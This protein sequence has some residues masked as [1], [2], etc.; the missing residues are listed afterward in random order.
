ML[1][2]GSFSRLVQCGVITLAVAL[3]MGG[4]WLWGGLPHYDQQ[5]VDN[6]ESVRAKTLALM[7]KAV[8][9]YSDHTDEVSQLLREIQSARSHAAEISGNK[10]CTDLWDI[11]LDPKGGYVGEFIANWKDQGK[12][13]SPELVAHEKQVTADFFDKIKAAEL[14]KKG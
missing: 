4:C 6:V 11:L 5:S 7:D 14:K 1:R 2:L 9:P 12:M 13:P 10:D 8:E 3:M